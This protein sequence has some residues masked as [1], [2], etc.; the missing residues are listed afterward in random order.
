MTPHSGPSKRLA[1]NCMVAVAAAGKI[2]LFGG[3]DDLGG[4]F[5]A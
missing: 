4:T 1:V 5:C 2:F 3:Y